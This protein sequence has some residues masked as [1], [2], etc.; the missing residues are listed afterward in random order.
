M[1]LPKTKT[2]QAVGITTRIPGR[3]SPS[4]LAAKCFIELTYYVR[5]FQMLVLSQNILLVFD[6]PQGDA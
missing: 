1:E 3:D 6:S 5:Y 2:L 4:T